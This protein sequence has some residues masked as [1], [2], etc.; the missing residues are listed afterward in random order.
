MCNTETGMM[1]TTQHNSLVLEFKEDL[2]SLKIRD[3]VRKH[4]TTGAPAILSA[5]DYYSLRQIVG[6]QFRVHPNCVPS[7]NR[8]F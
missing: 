5:A 1:E 8:I 2:L 6:D 4:I 7:A 3:V